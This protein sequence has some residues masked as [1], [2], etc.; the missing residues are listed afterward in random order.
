MKFT[1]KA[2]RRRFR[3]ERQLGMHRQ[4]ESHR[5]NAEAVAEDLRAEL[6]RRGMDAA[7][8]AERRSRDESL[9]HAFDPQPPGGTER[10]DEALPNLDGEG[11]QP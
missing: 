8:V 7:S 9:A 5:C 4:S 10:L 11:R 2:C 1:C 6:R 3:T